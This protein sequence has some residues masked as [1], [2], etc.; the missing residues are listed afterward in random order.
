VRAGQPRSCR[1]ERCDYS[2]G[3]GW[4]ATVETRTLMLD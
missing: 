3:E 1:V 2:A 4:F